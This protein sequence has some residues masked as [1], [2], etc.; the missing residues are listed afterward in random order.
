MQINDY[1]SRRADNDFIFKMKIGKVIHYSIFTKFN[2]QISVIGTF[3]RIFSSDHGRN[4]GA[5]WID[6]EKVKDF[7]PEVDREIE[8]EM[9]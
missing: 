3:G 1:V 6:Y 9:E 7:M 2:N 8:Q 4:L 5:C